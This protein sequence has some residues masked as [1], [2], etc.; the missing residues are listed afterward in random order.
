M[1]NKHNKLSRSLRD[2]DSTPKEI[3]AALAV[4]FAQHQLTNETEPTLEEIEDALNREWT[5]LHQNCIV[6]Q[7]PR[8]APRRRSMPRS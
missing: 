6:I 1:S 2:F 4:S 7:K 5:V 3:Y 8:R